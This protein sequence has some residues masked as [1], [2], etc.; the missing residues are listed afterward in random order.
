MGT[1]PLGQ[2]NRDGRRRREIS[3]G[4]IYNSLEGTL[5]VLITHAF[6]QKLG[7]NFNNFDVKSKGLS[8]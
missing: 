2:G 5:Y 3:H 7:S 6:N 1:I 4:V 8:C